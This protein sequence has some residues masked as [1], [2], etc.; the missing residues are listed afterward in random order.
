MKM[1]RIESLLAHF[2]QRKHAPLAYLVALIVTA[3]AVASRAALQ[4]LLPGSV[5]VTLY[6]AV[7][8]SAAIGGV[9][10]GLLST[11][12]GGL[13]TWY[14]FWPWA[15]PYANPAQ[16]PWA[17]VVAF[18][19]TCIIISF[20]M[21]WLRGAI[22]QLEAQRSRTSELLHEA[23]QSQARA[24]TALAEM[25]HRVKNSLQIAASL[26]RLQA[27]STADGT[28]DALQQAAARVDT[29]ARVHLHLTGL[30]EIEQVNFER[31]LRDFC[32]E[33]GETWQSPSMSLS[34]QIDCENLTVPTRQ[35]VA[36]GLIINELLTNIVKYAYPGEPHGTAT[37]RCQRTPEGAT[38]LR[39]ADDGVGLPV[40]FDPAKSHGL[41]MRIVAA[42][43]QQIG[44]DLEI[45][46]SGRS[47][48]SFM[49]TVPAA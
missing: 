20:V 24:E 16:S 39:I 3:G 11:A 30:K 32:N 5:F 13:A 27:G 36:L 45:E 34:W 48:A 18:A 8:I 41:G 10:A 2:A 17:V 22:R 46:R 31:Y 9:R 12:I 33:L 15:S 42:L 28:R 35:A 29:V 19:L 44:A 26:L 21:R 25:N 7:L 6:P 43:C 23:E 1:P 4:P 47:G 14:L 40:G 38:K 37:I 49:I